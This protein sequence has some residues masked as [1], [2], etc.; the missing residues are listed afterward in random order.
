MT[1]LER[2]ADGGRSIINKYYL[3]LT[4]DRFHLETKV[5]VPLKT[6]DENS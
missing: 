6:A 3:R 2:I 5:F 4:I 1:Y